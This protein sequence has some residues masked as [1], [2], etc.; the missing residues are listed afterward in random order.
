MRRLGSAFIGLRRKLR[1]VFL[2]LLA[3]LSFHQLSH[4]ITQSRKSYSIIPLSFCCLSPLFM[5]SIVAITL[6]QVKVIQNWCSS[7]FSDR[8][9]PQKKSE[10]HVQRFLIQCYPQNP[11]VTNHDSLRQPENNSKLVSDNRKDSGIIVKN[12]Q[13]PKLVSPI[14]QR[15]SNHEDSSK[16]PSGSFSTPDRRRTPYPYILILSSMGRSGSSFLGDLLGSLPGVFYLFEPLHSLHHLNQDL[17]V[18]SLKKLFAC[19][20]TGPIYQAVRARYTLNYK[21]V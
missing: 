16:N 13:V 3:C 21:F 11:S 12:L 8:H 20:Y 5:T 9:I 10:D 7:I 18:D 6:Q 17:A 1:M 15:P 4:L 19:N 2:I 14:S